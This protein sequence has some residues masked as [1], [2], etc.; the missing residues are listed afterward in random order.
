MTNRELTI[1]NLGE[2]LDKLMNLDPR[3]YGVCNIL[4]AGSREY[5]G[6]PLSTNA[7]KKLIDT[8]SEGDL[9][10]II[11]GFVLIPHNKAETDGMVSSLTLADFLIKAFGVRVC[12]I[13]PEECTNAVENVCKYFGMDICSVDELTDNKGSF[14]HV[15]FSKDFD[16]AEKMADELISAELPKAVLSIEAPGRNAV[17]KYHNAIGQDITD[18]E[19]KT[20]ILFEK[21][22]EKG[23]FNIAIGDLG[24][25][26][27]MGA[28]KD[29]IKTYIPYAAENECSCGCNGGLLSNQAADN[30]ITATVSD[31]GTNAMMA[32]MAYIADKHEYFNNAKQQQELMQICADSGLIDMY[33]EH[34]PRIDGIGGE[35]LCPIIELM[36]QLIAFPATV[37]DK[38]RTWFDKTIEK[39]YFE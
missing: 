13:T 30:I 39:G 10:Y 24:N 23:V 5:T 16:E 31:W 9:V 14:A 8:I 12:F 11:T 22:L 3:G 26:C 19:A 17:N 37:E 7:A 4:Y 33:G 29:H 32:A 28:I 36:A 20:D 15:V 35:I 21:L 6:E 38:T 18:L 1:R 27:G 2:N 34:I 25:E